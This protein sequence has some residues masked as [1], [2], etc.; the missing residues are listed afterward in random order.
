[1]GKV[2]R[3]PNGTF[4]WIDLGTPDV[5]GAKSFY[6]ELLG[7]ETEDLATGEN[8]TSTVC[9]LQG[10]DVAAI[11]ERAEGEGAQWASYISVDDVDATTA[12]A[13]QL[14]TKTL[15]EPFDVMDA[16]RRSLIQDPTGAEV[17][18]WQ[19]MGHI[20][21]R[22]VNEVGAWSWNELV[23]SQFDEARGF[24]ADLLGWTA[25][26]VP[27]AVRRASFSMGNLLIG[28]LHAPGEQEGDVSH[29][30]VSFT[31]AD[32][33]ESAE[34]VQELG[35]RVLLPPMDIPVGRFAIVADPAGAAFTLAAVPGGAFRGVDGS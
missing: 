29:W 16:G 24:Y 6:K 27:A 1:M 21:A 28:G 31:I 12:K 30:T 5:A 8:G 2:S 14:G 10:K 23:T 9:R 35:G 4:C 17:S 13:E 22:L 18:L 26:D 32:A 34:R 11:H 7:W 19:P 33:D 3:Y 25:E 15:R 20:G